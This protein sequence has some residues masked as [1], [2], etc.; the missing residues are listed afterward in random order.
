MWQAHV[1]GEPPRG[2]AEA[3]AGL[4]LPLHQ[5]AWRSEMRRC[6]LLR[7]ALYLIRP[8][9]YVALAD[10]ISRC[11]FGFVARAL[12][13]GGLAFEDD[14]PNKLAEALAAL[15]QGLRA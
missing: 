10:P 14:R 13:Y 5:F 7:A 1:Y 4:Q 8:D 9:G 6:G 12:H 3:C 15:E 2:L 11:R